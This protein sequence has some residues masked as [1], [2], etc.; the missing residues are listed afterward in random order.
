MLGDTASKEKLNYVID[1]HTSVAFAAA[2]KLGYDA[3]AMRGSS[4]QDTAV[5]I[6]ATASACKFEVA[7]T[8]AM[9]GDGWN[10]YKDG[11]VFPKR[12]NEYMAKTEKPPVE[13]KR[14][15]DQTLDEAQD[16]WKQRTLSLV[17]K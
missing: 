10:E 1:P 6:M 16:E 9:G 2:D 11:A 15:D 3:Y 12:A 4:I 13:Y 7:V 8:T 5:A 17:R 14:I